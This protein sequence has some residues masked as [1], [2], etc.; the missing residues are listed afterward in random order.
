MLWPITSPVE[1]LAIAGASGAMSPILSPPKRMP[2]FFCVPFALF[3]ARNRLRSAREKRI[4]T[5]EKVSTPPAITTS[6]WPVWM[7]WIPAQIAWFAEMH[8]CVTVC[9]G[10]LFGSPAPSAASRAM[11]DVRTSWSTVPMKT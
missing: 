3:I 11:F 7:C 6:D 1:K 5:S 10:M 2:S 8:A 4:G 9:A